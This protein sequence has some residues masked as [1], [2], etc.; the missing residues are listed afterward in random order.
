M[1]SLKKRGHAGTDWTESDYLRGDT[2][3]L[4][5][6]TLSIWRGGW[7]FFPGS[8]TSKYFL[9]PDMR[10]IWGLWFHRYCRC[11]CPIYHFSFNFGSVFS[12]EINC[13][14][15]NLSFFM[16]FRFYS[17]FLHA[18]PKLLPCFLPV[19]LEFGFLCLNIQAFIVRVYGDWNTM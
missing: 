4:S 7:K 15:S 3:V 18:V 1:R 9:S 5:S 14:V 16:T 8:S 6:S 11:V 17:H 19:I 10:G 12:M 13:H 2:L